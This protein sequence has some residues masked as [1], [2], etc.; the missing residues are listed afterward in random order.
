LG[1]QIELC[2]FCLFLLPNF[3]GYS[4]KNLANFVSFHLVTLT[5][6]HGAG[7]SGSKRIT[8]KFSSELKQKHFEMSF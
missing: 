2:F 4:L 5:V 6:L 1:F 7:L 3:L 8:S